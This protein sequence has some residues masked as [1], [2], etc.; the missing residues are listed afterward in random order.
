MPG[1]SHVK[2][3]EK[4]NAPPAS[5]AGGAFSRPRL[6]EVRRSYGA[7]PPRP[8][9]AL[10]YRAPR[11]P[12]ALAADRTSTA[13]MRLL[14]DRGEYPRPRGASR[15]SGVNVIRE[16]ELSFRYINA[17]VASPIVRPPLFAV[18]LSGSP[19]IARP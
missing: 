19:P 12:I 14:H 13:W 10:R 7:W 15:S 2:Q 1:P 18:G 11:S 3:R 6:G 8:M 5:C 17:K 9:P 16:M 4:Q